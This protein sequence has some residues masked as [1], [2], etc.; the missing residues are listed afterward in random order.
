M[1]SDVIEQRRRRWF[2]Y[3]R[4]LGLNDSLQRDI[5]DSIIPDDYP[6][7][8]TDNG[9]VSR[10]PLFESAKQFNQAVLRL[11]TMFHYR[12]KSHRRT[13]GKKSHFASARQLDYIRELARRL[14]WNEY[15]E[16]NMIYRLERFAAIK[17]SSRA[18]P[19]NAI[20]S[21]NTLT[22][23]QASNIIRAL[24]AMIAKQ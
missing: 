11:L 19:R 7:K 3:C 2:G 14:K 23:R 5:A 9:E 10:K 1:N 13:N 4:E 22:G 18:K 24:K 12:Q 16:E 21:L 20:R 8:F 17:T 6:G 15:G